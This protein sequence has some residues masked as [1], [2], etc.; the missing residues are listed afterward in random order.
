M[1][2]IS[3]KT[4]ATI[5]QSYLAEKGITLARG[6]SL[7]AIA[8]TE[9]FKNYRTMKG[10]L[11]P[12]PGGEVQVLPFGIKIRAANGGGAIVSNLLDQF[13]LEDDDEETKEKAETAS[14]ALESFLLAMACEGVDLTSPRIKAALKN[15]VESIAN[16]F[17]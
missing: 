10:A 5:L 9:G 6:L 16:N 7:E 15:A 3:P 8:K 12:Q 1:Q 17:D 11:A 2:D 14:D 13:V 4:K